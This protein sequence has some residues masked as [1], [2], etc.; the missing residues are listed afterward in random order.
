[1]HPDDS[2]TTL[3]KWPFILGDVL[4]V[5]SAL[6]I[7]VLGDWQLT[8][9]QV[10]SCVLAVALGAGL[11]VLPYIVEFRVRVEEEAQDRRGGV[12]DFRAPDPQLDGIARRSWIVDSW[13]QRVTTLEASNLPKLQAVDR[14]SR[15]LEAL[16]E[17]HAQTVA[18]LQA[19]EGSRGSG[20]GN[21]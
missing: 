12:A 21:R 4:L 9:W 6:A 14:L 13:R 1:M 3:S 16:A 8:N 10:A 11:F 7:A 17:K 19:A 15:E 5:A 2:K 20:N 18:A